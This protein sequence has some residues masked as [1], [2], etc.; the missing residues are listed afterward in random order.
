MAK[1]KF[2]NQAEKLFGSKFTYDMNSY[3]DDNTEMTISFRG[4]SF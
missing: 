4:V 2:L 3:V 1:Q